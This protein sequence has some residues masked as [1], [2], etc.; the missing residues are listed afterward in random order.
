[1]REEPLRLWQAW[2]TRGDARA[3]EELVRPD[4]GRAVALARSFGCPHGEAEDAV[5]ESLLRLAREKGDAPARAACGQVC[6][7]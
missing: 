4:L 1:M 7:G 2:R 5:Q 3:F 6:P